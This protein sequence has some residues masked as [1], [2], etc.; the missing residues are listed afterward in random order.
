M[1]SR[2]SRV[3]LRVLVT[4][5]CVA[6]FLVEL[7]GFIAPQP[8][9]PRVRTILYR[10]GVAL[11]TRL[12]PDDQVVLVKQ[13]PGLLVLPGKQTRQQKIAFL[14]RSSDVV[15]VAD[16][17]NVV[18]ELTTDKSW[19]NTRVVALAG[20]VL[21]SRKRP[22]ER[23]QQLDIEYEGGGELTIRSCLVK[24]GEPL[25]VEAGRRYL[26][27]LVV[28]PNTG[29]LL[30]MGTPLMIDN[31]KL[32]NPWIVELGSHARDLLHGLRLEQVAKEVRRFA[33]K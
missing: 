25:K 22:F 33:D 15:V 13:E 2:F 21:K 8:A 17:S 9:S 5:W 6:M 19:I 31:G 20:E 28:H 24:A 12:L 26:L 29:A 16:V 10:P 3:P 30:P 11:G 32:V 4:L 14:T 27:F 18:S 7:N 23:G 1:L